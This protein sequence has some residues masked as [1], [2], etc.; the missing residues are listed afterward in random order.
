MNSKRVV[1]GWCRAFKDGRIG[2][3]GS[4]V[5]VVDRFRRRG[6]RRQTVG[7]IGVWLRWKPCVLL[8]FSLMMVY[9]LVRS[10]EATHLMAQPL[11]QG[12]WGGSN[13]PS[14]FQRRSDG[15]PLK[16]QSKSVGIFFF[17]ATL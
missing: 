13:D 6:L 12:G 2:G 15:V 5:P 16:I 3:L 8:R 11:F 17:S 10:E 14:G 4:A 9:G 1:S 7:E